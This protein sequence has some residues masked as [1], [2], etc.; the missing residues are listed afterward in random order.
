MQ[1]NLNKLMEIDKT[2]DK[3]FLSK[4]IELYKEG[5]AF[6]NLFNRVNVHIGDKTNGLTE[7][8]SKAS[9]STRFLCTI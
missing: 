8:I 2:E 5:V 7:H 4:I 6:N 9:E 1:A 3:H